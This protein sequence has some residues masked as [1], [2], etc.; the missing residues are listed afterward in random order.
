ME[1]EQQLPIHTTHL[2]NEEHTGFEEYHSHYDN[3]IPNHHNYP[4]YDNYSSSTAYNSHNS[5]L[6]DINNVNNDN[7]S[8]SNNSNNNNNNNNNNNSNDTN[9]ERDSGPYCLCRGADDGTPMICCDTC[10]EWYHTRCV[11]LT[12]RSARLLDEYYC[13]KCEPSNTNNNNNTNDGD[14]ENSNGTTKGTGKA[15]FYCLG[16]RDIHKI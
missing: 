6:D 8:S 14:N 15:A 5:P 16:V 13:P 3:T 11:K 4:S 9:N 1:E 7:S 12:A 10:N 2:L